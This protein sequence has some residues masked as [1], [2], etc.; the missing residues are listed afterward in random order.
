LEHASLVAKHGVGIYKAE[1]LICQRTVD[2]GGCG[3]GR[4]GC[5]THGE[6]SH[7]AARVQF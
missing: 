6:R 4:G 7:A 5:G 2:S 3:R 1:R